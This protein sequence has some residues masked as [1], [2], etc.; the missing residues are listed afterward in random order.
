[1]DE[2]AEALALATRNG[3]ATDIHYP[4]HRC[5]EPEGYKARN[6]EIAEACTHLLAV[7]HVVTG[8]S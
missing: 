7:R 5:W 8:G 3:V 2:L 4:R 1:M 6:I